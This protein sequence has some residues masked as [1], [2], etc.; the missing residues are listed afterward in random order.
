[1]D[2][3]LMTRGKDNAAL[4]SAVTVT[5]TQG[6]T[7]SHC[8]PFTIQCTTTS[9][10]SLTPVLPYARYFL[11]LQHPLPLIL[12]YTFVIRLPCISSSISIYYVLSFHSSFVSF[13][14]HCTLEKTTTISIFLLPLLVCLNLCS[15]C[16]SIFFSLLIVISFALCYCYPLVFVQ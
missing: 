3:H 11:S 13:I 4:T 1:M 16:S 7:P 14:P 8:S 9:L 5:V 10:A 2:R 6:L 15:T 12:C